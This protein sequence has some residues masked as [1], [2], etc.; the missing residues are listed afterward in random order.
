MKYYIKNGMRKNILEAYDTNNTLVGEALI[1]P[2]MSSEIFDDEMK[3]SIVEKIFKNRRE[4][5]L[6]TGDYN[7]DPEDENDHLNYRETI[8]KIIKEIDKYCLYQQQTQGGIF[9][10]LALSCELRL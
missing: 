6:Y 8:D 2:F 7:Y 3:I 4:G 10:I 9:Y 1:S 5:V